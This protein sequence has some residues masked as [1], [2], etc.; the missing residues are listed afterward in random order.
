MTES[1]G[2]YE[3]QEPIGEGAMA[4]VYRALDREL[5]RPVAVK[6]L[7]D[8]SAGLRE[9]LKREALA[10]ARLAHPNVVTLYDVGEQGG[11]MY[12]VMEL[13]RGRPFDQAIETGRL[14]LRAAVELI[15]KVARGVQHAHEHGIVHRDLKPGN[16]LVR[17]DGEPKVVDF[18]LARVETEGSLT[19][20]GASVGTPHYMAPEQVRGDPGSV[21]PRSD[22]Y[23]LGAVLYEAMAGRRPHAGRTTGD[24]FTRILTQEPDDPRIGKPDLPRNL[25]TI[26]MKALD[27]SPVRRYR[28]AGDFADD[29]R[30]FLSG[31]D[32]VARPMS[33]LHRWGRG[34]SRRRGVW[35]AVAG[36][37]GVGLAL[38]IVLP[39]LSRERG[40]TARAQAGLDLWARISNVLL[41]ADRYSR[42]GEL[43]ATNRRLDDGIAAC[44][45]FLSKRDLPEAHYFLGRL[46]RERGQPGDARRELDRAIEMDPRL[47]EARLERGLLLI[48]EYAAA[49]Y[50]RRR[51]G[52]R[53]EQIEA[54]EPKLKDLREAAI[55][56][57][58]VEVGRS[59]YFQGSDAAYGRAELTRLRGDPGA[60]EAELRRIVER[61]PLHDRAW[62]ALARAAMERGAMQ[63]ALAHATAAIERH[64]G[65]GEA[66]Y[67]RAYFQLVQTQSLELKTGEMARLSEA[68]IRDADRAIELGWRAA[69]AYVARG[70]GRR[71]R[72]DTSGAI[73]DYTEA[74]R[75]DPDVSE[76]HANRAHL[77]WEAGDLQGAMQDFDAALRIAPGFGEVYNNRARLREAL[78][79]FE[80][81]VRDYSF[82]IQHDPLFVGPY[83]G[84]A[85]A[86]VKL[87][88][89]DAAM[90]DYDAAL[91]RDPRRILAY[92]NRALLKGARGDMEGAIADY[93][94]AIRIDP[95]FAEALNGRG[96]LKYKLRDAGGAMEDL[97]AALAIRPQPE[98]YVNRARVWV[99]KG[100]S[101]RGIADY[102]KALEIAPADWPH[103]A[104]VEERLR[105]LKGP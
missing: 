25:V 87:G 23:A 3:L 7:K 59:S 34:I 37:A 64:R 95:E 99:M 46:L 83:L 93:D 5:N 29:L 71:Q 42:A 39:M 22:V 49:V 85:H 13:V 43:D 16:I 47:G 68:A 35:A 75:L 14:S 40:E 70:L 24:I 17:E 66:Y 102:A 56:D 33:T 21:G 79:D 58:A 9:R 26:A 31:E 36:I 62:V 15:E 90:A 48:D 54:Q 61:W 101:A 89:L 104:N 41:E 4:T 28:S 88:R 2:R 76:A 84:R 80:G 97:D 57:L 86:L 6:V 91:Q 51:W 50:H 53:G 44:R 63:E 103:R 65:R 73:A 92:Y 98:T 8:L 81:A 94:A 12:L 27:K 38:A 32:I 67:L 1:F 60:A 20:T 19:A 30:R 96:E 55:R 11:R 10:I 45:E 100:D 18:G 69:P 78:G 74:L 72:G 105:A 82:V 77:R 52:A